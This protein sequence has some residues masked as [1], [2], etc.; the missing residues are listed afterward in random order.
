MASIRKRGKQGKYFS[1]IQWRDSDGIWNEESIDLYTNKKSTAV[2]RNAEVERVEDTIKAGDN[3]SFAWQNDD[4]KTNLIK[5][6]LKDAYEEYRIVQNIDGVRASTLDRV[7]NSMKTLYKVFG[8]DYPIASL[9]YS[10]IEQFK[11][12]WHGT[13]QPTTMNI[14]LSKIKA[15]HN[16]CLKKRYTIKDVE[17]KMV[18]EDEKPPQY[19]TDAEFKSIMKCDIIDDHFKKAFVFYL[20]TGCRK[21][22]PFIADL[23]G[24]WLT[25]KSTDAKS[26]RTRDIELNEVTKGIVQDM[27]DRY[28]Y[29]MDEYGQKPRNVIMN[30]GKQFKKACRHLG[31]R[32]KTL[33][34]LRHTYA[35][36]RWAITGDIKMVSQEIGHSS[37][38]M[39]EK[40]AKFNL[41]KLRDD[42]PSLKE[43][44]NLRLTP[45]SEDSYFTTLL[46][47][48]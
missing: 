12:Y 46:N 38:V 40:Y 26:H 27:R 25:I 23:N 13:H 35:V 14:N 34:S 42:F 16:W 33:H 2:V 30:Y 43:R 6:S 11:E 22:E 32:G 36:R 1:R 8:E 18:K 4:G 28:H 37:V 5:L 15:F 31:I 48:I 47:A 24:N 19:L 17:F 41:R 45:P 21:T 10:H 44:I 39:T 29:Y 7:D 3:W 20:Y 9:T